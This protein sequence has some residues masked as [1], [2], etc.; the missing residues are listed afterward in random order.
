MKVSNILLTATLLLASTA[1]YAQTITGAGATFPAPV[2]SKWAEAAKA[3]TGIELNYQAI[4]SG[5]GQTQIINRTVDFGASDAPVPAD[6]LAANNL[7][8][9]PTVMGA[10]VVIVN[11]PGVETNQVKLTGPVLADIYSG[12]IRNWNNPAIQVL[13]PDKTLPMLAIAPVYRA[14]GS[15]TTYVWTSYLSKVSPDW[16]K[17]VGANTSVKWP[18][19][20]GAKGN[21]GVAATVKQVKGAMGYVESVYASA[22]KLI[23]TQLQNA[24]HKW[25]SP[26][27]QSFQ[28]AAQNADWANAKNWEVDIINQ[29][30]A[31]SWPVVSATYLLLPTDP[32]NPAQAQLVN[33]WLEWA[34]DQGGKLATDMDYIPL[35]EKVQRQVLMQIKG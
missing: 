24:D 32:K 26:N 25:V 34:Y 35:P 20:N 13:N 14:D 17:T 33:K 4:G 27:S 16:A 12:K 11:I 30:G 23:T 19:G 22:N 18:I 9:V 15:G 6:K 29:P 1:A 7:R 3:A 21:D 31:A 5:G 10:V 8:Q 2:Y 28:A